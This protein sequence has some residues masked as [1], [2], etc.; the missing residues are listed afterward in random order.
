MKRHHLIV[1]GVALAFALQAPA[2]AQAPQ[3]PATRTPIRHFVVL[4]EEKRSFDSYFGDY[5]GAEGMPDDACVLLGA[6][7][8]TCAKPQATQAESVE[9]L[10]APARR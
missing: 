10:D 3:P 9:I 7:H 5:P 2:Q 8:K 1:A 6:A 4:M